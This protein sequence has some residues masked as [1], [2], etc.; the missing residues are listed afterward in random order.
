VR[1]IKPLAVNHGHVY[2]ACLSGINDAA[3]AR[4]FAAARAEAILGYQEYELRAGNHQLFSFEAS[5]W[6]K[7]KQL[8][9]GG[10]TKEEFVDLYLK[11][12]VGDEKPGRKYYDQLMM[13]APLQKCPFC[14]FG[15]ARTLDHFL[16]KAL[17]PAFS[18]L[19]SNLVPSCTDCNKGKSASALTQADQILHPY[20]EEATVESECWL[21]AEVIQSAPATVRYFVKPP[22]LWSCKLKQRIARHFDDF[23]LGKRFAVEAGTDLA[24]LA[25]SLSDQATINAKRD[26]LACVSMTEHK[27]YKNSWKAALYSALASS[28]WYLSGGYH[29]PPRQSKPL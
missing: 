15:Q 23:D 11:Q 28:E 2:D 8:V 4:R 29:N 7:E 18:I 1:R 5:Q 12:M 19:P 22:D 21:F 17:Y 16:S 10:M 13:L 9:L 26:H 24:G 6:G 27:L 25:L 3:L 14:G 20:F